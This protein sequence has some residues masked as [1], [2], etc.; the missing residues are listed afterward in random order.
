MVKNA[1]IVNTLVSNLVW[2]VTIQRTYPSAVHII[3][4]VLQCI[5]PHNCIG[6]LLLLQLFVLLWYLAYLNVVAVPAVCVAVGLGILECC[7]CITA[8]CAAK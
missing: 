3:N 1:H 2:I 8:V 7:C 6:M 4:T 5:V